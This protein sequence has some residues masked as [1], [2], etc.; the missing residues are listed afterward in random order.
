MWGLQ[1]MQKI[2]ALG[3]IVSALLSVAVSSAALAAE[4]TP[5]KVG[6]V[7][8][9]TGPLGVIGRD[10]VD[11]F[12]LAIS[13]HGGKLGGRPVELIVEDDQLKPDVGV[14]IAAK[15]VQSDKVDVV[16]SSSFS[17]VLLAMQKSIN[18][19]GTILITALGGPSPL[20]G[21]GCHPLFFSTSA[22]N[23]SAAEAM[24]KVVSDRG[25]KR[26][27]VMAPNTLAGK[28]IIA[29]FKRFYKGEVVGE[30]YTALGQTDY[31]AELATVRSA[32]PDAVFVFYGGAMGSAFIRQYRQAGL[33]QTPLYSVFT[34]DST[35]LPAMG[36]L[37]VGTFTTA[38]WNADFDN[39]AN[40]RFVAD[41]Q[42]AY[43]RVP[44][45]FAAR[46]YDTAA[47]L[48][49]ALNATGGNSDSKVLREALRTAKFDATRGNFKLNPA[50]QWPIQDYYL[51]EIVK[52]EG[53]APEMVTRT[54]V[55]EAHPDP[56]FRECK[57]PG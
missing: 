56:F 37:A 43:H 12:K 11:G 48:N 55:L 57:Y 9:L 54:K 22:V 39:P 45:D 24:G 38:L 14:E 42:A 17:H 44:G 41:F 13:E 31:Q 27:Y 51:V 15:F 23:D 19:A 34:V 49:A 10:V 46:A 28:D 33:R 8:A 2:T 5:L 21:A 40:K 25:A 50:N 18:D 7:T 47:L 6:L 20:A 52:P 3:R 26:V 36:D 35:T 29:G 32:K 16:V 4:P 30:T 1:A 53:K